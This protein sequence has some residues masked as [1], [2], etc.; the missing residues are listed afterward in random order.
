MPNRPMTTGTRPMPSISSSRPKVR[1]GCAVMLSSP[2]TPSTMPM[3][4]ISNAFAIEPCVRKVRTTRPSTIRLKYSA[5]P[6]A[7]ATLA[8]LGATSISAI[9]AKVPAKNEPNAEMPS[10]GP[11]R[12]C[13]A[14]WWPSI[15]VTT[16]AASPGML[17]RIEVVEPP[18]IEP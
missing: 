2:T 9:S 8:S 4:A 12:P 18:Y 15:Q 14:I 17:T 13:L 10:A 3:Q 1:R 5:G 6:K 16:E 11:A 7:I